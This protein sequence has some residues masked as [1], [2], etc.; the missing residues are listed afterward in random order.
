MKIKFTWGTGLLITIIVFVTFFISFI[1]FSLTQ[2]INLVSKDYFPDEIAYETKLQKIKNANNLK[3]NISIEKKDDKIIFKYPKNLKTQISGTILFYYVT[4]RNFDVD[5]KIEPNLD[6]QQLIYIEKLKK[7]RYY[8]QIDWS[9]N[10]SDYF[11]EFK[12][13]F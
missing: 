10:K 7:G 1:V 4:D 11:Q 8:I 2:D 6:N 12:I 13:T 9:S 3:E 5:F